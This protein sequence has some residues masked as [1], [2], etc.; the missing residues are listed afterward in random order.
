[1]PY[2][3]IVKTT[4]PGWFGRRA[5]RTFYVGPFHV[6]SRAK[7]AKLFMPDRAECEIVELEPLGRPDASVDE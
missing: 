7:T 1:V 4:R 2:I 6:E 3:L 5:D